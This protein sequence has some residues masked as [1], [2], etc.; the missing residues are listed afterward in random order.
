MAQ[1]HQKR[2]HMHHYDRTAHV[3][4][5]RYTEE[6]SLK[7]ETALRNLKLKSDSAMVDL[8]C[9]T[10]LLLPK[11]RKKAKTIVCL[12]ISKG[13]LNE[14]KH[15]TRHSADIHLIQADADYT[16]LL[17]GQF[18]LTFAITLL[19]N[20]PRPQQTLQEIKRITKPNARIVVTGL[21][22]RFTQ[23]SFLKLLK[24]AGLETQLTDADNNL[25]CHIATCR[26]SVAPRNLWR[27]EPHWEPN[28]RRNT[29]AAS[30]T[31]RAKA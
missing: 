29:K 18:D 4:N 7:T 23:Q 13:M 6:Q 12:D 19:Q 25:K 10:G 5:T 27:S 28:A 30:A 11:I 31:A 16:P 24:E 20:M 9:G 15:N 3:Y 2:G 26:K 21:K 14:A 1:W 8:G 17:P 22:K